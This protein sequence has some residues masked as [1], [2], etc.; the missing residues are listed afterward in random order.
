VVN[1][2][3][4]IIGVGVSGAISYSITTLLM[5]IFSRYHFRNQESNVTLENVFEK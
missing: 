5:L 3:L 1:L 4:G 2:D